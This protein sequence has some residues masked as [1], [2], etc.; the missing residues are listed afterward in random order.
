MTR[1]PTTVPGRVRASCRGVS[2]IEVMVAVLVL[3]FGLLGLSALQTRALRAN[4]SAIQ[5]SQATVTS[6]YILDIM[7][8]DREQAR[9]RNYNTGT[10][11][12]CH[13]NGMTSTHPLAQESLRQWLRDIKE[14][15]GR[16][17]DTSTCARVECDS[18]YVCTV[19][20]RWDD[21]G[22]GGDPDQQV[23]FTSRL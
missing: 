15:V 6:Q 7:R 9:L 10:G 18:A 19:Q 20:I 8:V 13:V 4:V 2:L 14:T 21:S 1:R 3:A 22:A 5:R 17:G 12:T 16:V 23:T 11:F